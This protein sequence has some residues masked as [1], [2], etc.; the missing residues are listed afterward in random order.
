M[1]SVSRIEP[2][3]RTRGMGYA[4]AAELN[5]YPDPKHVLEL[6]KELDLTKRQIQTIEKLLLSGNGHLVTTPNGNEE[7]CISHEL[8]CKSCQYNSRQVYLTEN[9]HVIGSYLEKAVMQNLQLVI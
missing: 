2:R 5:S 7:S 8:L 9:P 4:K 3:R 6:S 1:F